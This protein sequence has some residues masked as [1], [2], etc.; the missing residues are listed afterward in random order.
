M[1]DKNVIREFCKKYNIPEEEM[2]KFILNYTYPILKE[3]IGNMK[4]EID[5]MIIKAM[6]ELEDFAEAQ[7]PEG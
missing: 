6:D 5:S 7:E 1:L 2:D 4:E 3:M